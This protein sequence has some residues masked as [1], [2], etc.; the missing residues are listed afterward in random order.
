MWMTLKQ[1]LKEKVF[2]S[3]IKQ[4]K[5]WMK[6]NGNSSIFPTW[7]YSHGYNIYFTFS[8]VTPLIYH[9]LP[10]LW[11]ALYTINASIFVDVSYWLPYSTDKFISCVVLGSS[12]WFFHFG[13]EI[14]IPWTHIGWVLSMFQN[15]HCQWRKRWQ[16]RCDSLL[17]HEEWWGSVP[18]S[19]IF[20]PTLCC[21]SHVDSNVHAIFVE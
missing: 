16:Q 1:F 20:S 12:Q 19:V 14:V 17:Y 2:Y 11:K 10:N 4:F 18:L 13:K 9:L 5:G 3:S 8:I 7:L 21:S 15:L 6:S